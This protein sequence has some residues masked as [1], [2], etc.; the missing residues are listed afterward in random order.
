MSDG[1]DVLNLFAYTCGFSVA[2]A[3]GGANSTVSVDIS[4][5]NLDWGKANFARNSLEAGDHQF[6]R[7]DAAAYL[8]RA[9]R[10][11]K[12]FD[13]IVVDPP[14]FSHGRRRKQSFSVERDLTH[15]IA[16]SVDVLRSGGVMMLSTSYRKLSIQD[17]RKRAQAGA[18]GRRFKV[19]ATPPL[20]IDYAMDRDHAKTAFLQFE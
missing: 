5:G 18:R 14:T 1:K 9:H 13:L 17:L 16:A 8:E 11:S 10:Q 19:I 7:S 4:P 20:P 3:A 6:I 2:A 15:L 12:R